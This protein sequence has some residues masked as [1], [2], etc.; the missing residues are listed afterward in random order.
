MTSSDDESPSPPIIQRDY[1]NTQP[2]HK[3]IAFVPAET[4]SLPSTFVN[5]SGFGDAYLALVLPP[6][7][8]PT[9]T[10]T[11]ALETPIPEPPTPTELPLCP[12][13]NL[14]L[15]SDHVS[16]LA[17]QA[18]L[19]H[20]HT[21]LA[22]DR[23]RKGMA[24]L[25]SYGWDPDARQGLGTTSEGR[26]YPI[27][28]KEKPDKGGIGAE[29]KQIREEKKKVQKLNIKQIKEREKESKKK[30]DRLQRMFY[31]NG[32]VEKYLGGDAF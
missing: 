25:K 26:L 29:P 6:S 23:R 32:D 20:T 12:T 3:P 19:P 31:G 21:P 15:T 2:K 8:S 11:P 4:T 18:S 7:E 27:K 28:A 10:P 16:S 17:H 22:L 9:P 30:A 13:C 14:P 24:Y 5:K 1:R